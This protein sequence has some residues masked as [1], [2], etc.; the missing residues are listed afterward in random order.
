MDK[1]VWSKAADDSTGLKNYYNQNKQKYI[2]EPSL[3][4]LVISGP[5]KQTVQHIADTLK[6][7]SNNWRSIIE[8]YNGNVAADSSRFENGQSPVKQEVLM[9]E[10]FQT[11][12]ESNEAGDSYTFIRVIK[13]FPQPSQRSFDEARGMVINDYQQVLEEKWLKELKA[14]YPVKV[15]QAVFKTL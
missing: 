6:G 1:H 7:N 9:Q 5:D 3:T 14:K 11:I 15:N 8:A 10:G 13:I 4:A 2:W 12:P